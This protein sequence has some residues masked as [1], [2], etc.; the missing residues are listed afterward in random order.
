M[1]SNI[2]ECNVVDWY[3]SVNAELKLVESVMHSSIMSDIHSVQDVADGILSAGGKR[4]RP[5]LV[6]LS[7]LAC[8]GLGDSSE[9]IELAAA[10]ELVHTASLVH[11]DVV[12]DAAQR[13]GRPT[14]N[15]SWGSKISVLS[16]DYMLSKAFALLAR[17]PK[18]E[19]LAVISEAAGVMAES[20][21]LETEC[22]GSLESWDTNY[23]KCI[24]GK[25]AAF[26]CSCCVCGAI[27]ADAGIE[28]REALREYGLRIGL[29]FQIS[30]DILDVTGR[31]SKVGK[32]LGADIKSGKYTLPLL[33][34]IESNSS[35]GTSL[36]SNRTDEKIE[37]ILSSVIRCGAVEKAKSV[38]A[39]Q[40]RIAS[41]AL[42]VF[43]ESIYKRS[44]LNL[45]EYI[46]NRQH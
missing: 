31:Q 17:Q 13:R 20:Q 34:A 24:E 39:E 41:T 16:G 19:I 2:K 12:D 21:V 32:D 36:E 43:P 25:T 7:S 8:G 29:S 46:V 5:T 45:A 44:L 14:A 3:S 27:S 1:N 9:I 15:S 38:A 28:Y 22:L 18:H 4:I 6:L 40:C 30:D 42:D 33:L 26:M 23:W 37:E 35:I 10:I 11:D